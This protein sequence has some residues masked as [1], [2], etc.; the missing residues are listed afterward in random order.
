MRDHSR[1]VYFT[2][3]RKVKGH[4][5]PEEVDDLIQEGFLGLLR[6]AETFDPTKGFTWSTYACSCI[7]HAFFNY[8]SKRRRPSR[9]GGVREVSLDRPARKGDRPGEGITLGD[10]IPGDEDVEAAAL[11]HSAPDVDA[12]IRALAELLHPDFDR[13]AVETVLIGIAEGRGYDWLAEKLGLGRRE[14]QSLWQQVVHGLRGH[15]FARTL[16]DPAA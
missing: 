16:L 13:C 11:R 10:I 9:G 7:K 5:T 1:L 8:E 12:T 6:A 14:A 3:K 2:F 4:F 15:Q